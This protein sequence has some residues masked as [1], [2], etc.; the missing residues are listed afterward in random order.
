MEEGCAVVKGADNVR[1]TWKVA[2]LLTFETSEP[3]DG[4]AVL[5]S[6]RTRD[7]HVTL[8]ELSV[9]FACFH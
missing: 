9:R 4:E 3:E 5:A 1:W 2:E 8:L 6:G 7:K